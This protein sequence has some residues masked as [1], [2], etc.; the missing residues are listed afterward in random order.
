LAVHRSFSS[1]NIVDDA[2]SPKHDHRDSL[3]LGLLHRKTLSGESSTA[4]VGKMTYLDWIVIGI[5]AALWV[6]FTI[7]SLVAS[8]VRKGKV[9]KL[10][11]A[12]E[13]IED[14]G[15]FVGDKVDAAEDVAQSCYHCLSTS[16]GYCFCNS[17]PAMASLNCA[18]I[19]FVVLG[20]FL[21]RTR[22]EE[23]VDQNV[24]Y[25]YLIVCFLMLFVFAFLVLKHLVLDEMFDT[26]A[27]VRKTLH[28]L[29][30]FGLTGHDLKDI[31]N[32]GKLGHGLKDKLSYGH[33]YAQ[34]D[35]KESIGKP[36]GCC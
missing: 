5:A 4:S 17:S 18:F 26:M 1:Q 32:L 22:M 3:D 21:L 12:G 9:P 29:G 23:F 34:P 19:L 10:N 6:S 8:Y 33:N 27:D 16:I 31:G 30:N 24:V 20:G 36:R 13:V 2:S 25:A 14:A 15:D 7:A 11:D 28:K 35:S